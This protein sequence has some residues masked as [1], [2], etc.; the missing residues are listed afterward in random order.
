[1]NSD[2]SFP[3]LSSKYFREVANTIKRHDQGSSH[4]WF[5]F[6]SCLRKK[7]FGDV[8]VG[9]IGNI[10]QSL[11]GE[12]KEIFEESTIP[13]TIDIIPFD[14]TTTSFQHNVLNGPIKWIKR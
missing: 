4:Q 9:V 2:I 13:Y 10:D 6:G 7:H 1:M 12:L 5:L 14:Q 3:M 8:D 11:I